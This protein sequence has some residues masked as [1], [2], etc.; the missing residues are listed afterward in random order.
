MLLQPLLEP[1]VYQ[2][3]LRGQLNFEAVIIVGNHNNSIGSRY[4]LIGVAWRK[5]AQDDWAGPWKQRNC[6]PGAF[7]INNLRPHPD[8]DAIWAEYCAS[9]LSD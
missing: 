6:G 4:E 9:Q 7:T 8:G 1:G 3:W 2:E 5:R